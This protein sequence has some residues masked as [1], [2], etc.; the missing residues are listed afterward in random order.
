L[1][2]AGDPALKIWIDG[3]GAV[4]AGQKA[5]TC[6]VFENMEV[7]T[8]VYNAGTNNEMEYRALLQALSDDRARGATIFTDSQLLV[9]QLARGWKVNAENLKPLHSQAKTLLEERRAT[10]LWVPREQNRAGKVLEKAK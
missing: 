4:L 2:P 8:T 1:S 7:R 10:L 6:V 3:G 5:R 9:G